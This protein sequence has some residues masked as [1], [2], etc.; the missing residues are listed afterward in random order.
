[1]ST[2]LTNDELRASPVPVLVTN[3]PAVQPVSIAAPIAVT[4]TFWQ[5]TQPV[6]GTF[7]QTIQPVSGA[8][9]VSGSVS[10]SNFP[11]VGPAFF[12]TTT[13]DSGVFSTTTYG[14]T[15]TNPGYKGAWVSVI[16][17]AASGGP[18]YLNLQWSPDGGT[19]WLTLTETGTVAF[20]Y[21]G[22]YV[23]GV[24][25]GGISGTSS[26]NTSGPLPQ[27]WRVSFGVNGGSCTVSEVLVNYVN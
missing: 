12:N 3:L 19:T 1:M 13:G 23:L 20:G 7:W 26:S 4:G 25:P 27:T 11:S 15:Q 14:A 9:S 22:I 16:I 10:V 17:S 18:I 2:A 6:S 8:V 5:T 24:Y 21:P